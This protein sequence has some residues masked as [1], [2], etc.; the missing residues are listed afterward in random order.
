MNFADASACRRCKKDLK[1]AGSAAELPAEPTVPSAT[2]AGG[3]G[4]APSALGPEILGR[5]ST[6]NGLR[7]WFVIALDD[8]IVLAPE[9]ILGSVL[10]NGMPMLARSGL[11]GL[12]ILYKSRKVATAKKHDLTATPAELLRSDPVNVVIPL[13]GLRSIEFTRHIFSAWVEFAQRTGWKKLEINPLHYIELCHATQLRFPAL[14]RSDVRTVRGLEEYRRKLAKAG[15]P[16]RTER[17][18]HSTQA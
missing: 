6:K 8:S 9:S 11:L 15:R 17:E 3:P 13:A 4:V 16:A 14:Y 5:V 2:V 7:D 1:Q 10:H 18:T 12:L